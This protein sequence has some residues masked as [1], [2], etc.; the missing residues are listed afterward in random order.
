[1][2]SIDIIGALLRFHR[3]VSLLRG[4]N[5]YDV[6][7]HYARAENPPLPHH[8]FKLAFGKSREK[9][10]KEQNNVKQADAEKTRLETHLRRKNLKKYEQLPHGEEAPV[11]SN[12]SK[13]QALLTKKK[14]QAKSK[15]TQLDTFFFPEE[16]IRQDE[17]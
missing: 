16:S 8:P 6:V 2:N 10:L 13:E 3:L 1:M 9:S 15:S 4:H 11:K 7:E 12:F 17:V 5:P 14:V